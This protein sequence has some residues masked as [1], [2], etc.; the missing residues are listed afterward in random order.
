MMTDQ[1]INNTDL[2]NCPKCNH[3]Q[4]KE[5]IEC[6]KCGI[7]FSKFNPALNLKPVQD[8]SESVFSLKD[9]QH[10]ASLSELPYLSFLLSGQPS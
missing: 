10:C 1:A 9:L 8:A 5:T 3:A 7:I 6:K 4:A 2:F